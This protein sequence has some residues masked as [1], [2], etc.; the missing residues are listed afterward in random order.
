[1]LLDVMNEPPDWGDVAVPAFP[2]HAATVWL[3]M[4]LDVMKEPPDCGD[5][6]VAALPVVF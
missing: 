2:V 3:P 4:L 1:M 6:A 5:V